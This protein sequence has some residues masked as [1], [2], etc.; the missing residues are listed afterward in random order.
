MV[1]RE[2]WEEIQRLRVEDRLSVSEISRR[3]GLDRKT[4]RKWLRQRRWEPYQRPD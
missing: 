3:L 1:R 4:V 2:R